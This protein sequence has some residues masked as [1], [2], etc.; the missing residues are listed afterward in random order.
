MN[1]MGSKKKNVKTKRG[2][3]WKLFAMLLS[4]AV[5]VGMWQLNKA[6]G[7]LREQYKA[8]ASNGVLLEAQVKVLEGRAE[9]YGLVADK[10]KA[11][12]VHI[13]ASVIDIW[14]EIQR[15]MR[16]RQASILSTEQREIERGGVIEEKLMIT[17]RGNYLDLMEV[18][19]DMRKLPFVA[20]QRGMTMRNLPEKSREIV[21]MILEVNVVTQ[22]VL[23]SFRNALS[24]EDE[25]EGR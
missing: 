8:A 6:N 17:I 18:L 9:Y 15:I 13:P 23:D 5:I 2:D 11:F 14:P 3:G 4:L 19:G 7:R 1:T 25:E 24:F 21:E 20:L 10:L 22:R 16:D 12:D